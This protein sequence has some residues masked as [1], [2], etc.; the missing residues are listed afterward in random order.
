MSDV[1]AVALI[2]IVPSTITGI[3]TFLTHIGM[4]KTRT[5][6]AELTS[7]TNSIKDALVKTTGEAEFA[8]GLKQGQDE[9]RAQ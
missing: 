4:Q 5:D 9:E 3:V 1:V 8:K 2:S 6:M 7:N